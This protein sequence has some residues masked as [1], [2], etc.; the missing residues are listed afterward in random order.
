MV[1]GMGVVSPLGSDLARFHQSLREGRN[2]ISPIRP[3]FETGYK[4]NRAGLVSDLDLSHFVDLSGNGAVG[5]TSAL[6]VAACSM[7]LE[8]ADLRERSRCGLIVGSAMGEVSA[9]GP[10]VGS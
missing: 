8:H 7:A 3:R 10:N 4:T 9:L 1:T 5:R 2:G 6:A